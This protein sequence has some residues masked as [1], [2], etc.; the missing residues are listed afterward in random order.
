MKRMVIA[1]VIMILTIAVAIISYAIVVRPLEYTVDALQEAY[2][3]ISDDM[4]WDDTD[5]VNA[6]LGSLPYYLAGAL[7]F[8]IFMVFLWYAIYGHKKEFEQE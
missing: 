5:E 2:T 6:Q 8:L 1:T 7:V 3:D 4:E